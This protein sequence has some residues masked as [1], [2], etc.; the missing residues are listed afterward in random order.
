MTNADIKLCPFFLDNHVIA[1]NKC[2]LV[3][4]IRDNIKWPAR[5]NQECVYQTFSLSLCF[6][7][8][9]LPQTHPQHTLP[10]V[11]ISHKLILDFKMTLLPFLNAMEDLRI[12]LCS[13]FCSPLHVTKLSHACFHFIVRKQKHE[14]VVWPVLEENTRCRGDWITGSPCGPPMVQPHLWLQTTSLGTSFGLQMCFTWFTQEMIK[15]K[16]LADI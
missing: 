8:F 9:P 1:K 5:T 10:R 3:M 4:R 6:C 12:P 13:F 11:H 15:T 14:E 7:L 16:F 2:L